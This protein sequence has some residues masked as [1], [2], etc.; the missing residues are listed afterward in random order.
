MEATLNIPVKRTTHSA[1]GEVDWENLSFG[2]HVSDHM[3]LC[4][5]K[6]GGWQEPQ[7]LPFQPISLPPTALALHYGQAVFEGMK[8]FRMQDGRVNIFRT[9]RHHERLNAS[10]HRMCMPSIP[11]DLFAAALHQLIEAD[12]AWVPEGEDKALYIR[13][14]VFASKGRF[15]VKVAEE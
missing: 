4:R 2:S 3:F 8:A 15:G 7:I 1:I 6:N 9:G 11:Y 12:K 13:P 10:L 5:Y 14:L